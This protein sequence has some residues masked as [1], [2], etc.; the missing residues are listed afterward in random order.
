MDV[1]RSTPPFSRQHLPDLPHEAEDQLG[2]NL[3]SSGT[4]VRPA[5]ARPRRA[6]AV[7]ERIIRVGVVNRLSEGLQGCAVAR[8]ACEYATKNS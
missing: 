5:R 7:S 8:K 3:G 1:Q 4:D 6:E 2:G